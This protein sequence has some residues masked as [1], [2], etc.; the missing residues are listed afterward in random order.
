M[1][2]S[3]YHS[4]YHNSLTFTFKDVLRFDSWMK[5]FWGS[6]QNISSICELKSSRSANKSDIISSV[7][8]N[9]KQ[10]REDKYHLKTTAEPLINGYSKRS[11]PPTGCFQV[12]YSIIN[13]LWRKRSNTSEKLGS[14]WFFSGQYF[15]IL[16]A[17]ILVTLTMIILTEFVVLKTRQFE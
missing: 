8:L 13:W 14:D 16:T 3:F 6:F 12:V 7:F 17:Q 4:Y 5:I 11:F 9:L 2:T 1:W 15:P 10:K